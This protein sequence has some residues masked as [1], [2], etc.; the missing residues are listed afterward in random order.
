VVDAL[1]EPRSE[2]ERFDSGRIMSIEEYSF[3]EERLLGVVVFK[4]PQR[5]LGWPY[6]TDPFVERVQAA[7]LK[8]FRF[9]PVWSSD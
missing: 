6:V 8:G 7:K 1:D 4:L 3:I 5:P 2:V 9:R